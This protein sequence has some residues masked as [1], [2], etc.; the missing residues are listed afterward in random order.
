MSKVVFITGASRGIG[1]ACALKFAEAGWSVAANYVSDD[2]KALSLKSAITDKGGDC[3]LYKFDV[4]LPEEAEK[5]VAEVIDRYGKIDVF[6]SNAGISLVDYFD[7]VSSEK[8]RRIFDVNLIGAAGIASLVS[9][10]MLKFHKG[11][12]IF[13]SS[14]WGVHGAA[15]EAHYS[16]SKAGLIGLAKSMAK[17]LGP[18][19]ITV[20][21]IAPG[22]ID[23][24]MNRALS[25]S[26]MDE[27]INSTPLG[28]L[29]KPEEVADLALFLAEKGDFITGQVIGIDGGFY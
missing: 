26:V 29:G 6:I 1:R 25:Q 9:R 19:G 23:T 12:I 10:N 14:V 27:V 15:M 18:S 8:S 22:A 17:E 21:C 11:K 28:R 13:I 2:E 7:A 24:D 4:S 5:G 3:T 16:A 20:N